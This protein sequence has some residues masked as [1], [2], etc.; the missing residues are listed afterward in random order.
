[1]KLTKIELQKI[2][3]EE[4]EKM[5]EAKQLFDSSAQVE[6]TRGLR[7]K[8][9]KKI[10]KWSYEYEAMV[11]SHAYRLDVGHGEVSLYSSIYWD[12]INV[13]GQIQGVIFQAAYHG[14]R[15]DYGS[16]K[17][18]YGKGKIVKLKTVPGEGTIQDLLK[19]LV[20]LIKKA[21]K[22]P[23]MKKFIVDPEGSKDF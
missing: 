22:S 23:D 6:I 18:I 8:L 20:P 16:Y 13:G 7:G 15:N 4:I 3:K 14:D 10:G 17:E 19:E 5:D 2:I 12:E 9:P 21:M 1:M 11:G